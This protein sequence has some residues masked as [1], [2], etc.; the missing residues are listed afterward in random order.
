MLDIRPGSNTSVTLMPPSSTANVS[1]PSETTVARPLTAPP[2]TQETLLIETANSH[3]SGTSLTHPFVEGPLPTPVELVF[4]NTEE[5]APATV[6]PEQSDIEAPL[7]TL[8]NLDKPL[9]PPPS[10][11]GPSLGEVRSKPGAVIKPGE[12]SP[13][14]PKLHAMLGKLGYKVQHE[15]NCLD[16][17]LLRA[18]TVFQADAGIAKR[19]SDYSGI[20]GP[21]TLKCLDN[22]VKWG[23]LKDKE[24]ANSLV[25]AGKGVYTGKSKCLEGVWRT[26]QAVFN[27]TSAITAEK[28]F[29]AADEL[30]RDK[31][32]KE[33]KVTPEMYQA[34]MKGDKD[35]QDL[36]HGV[37]VIYNRSSGFSPTSGHAEIW[38]MKNKKTL[39]G[40]G[41]ASMNRSGHMI[42]NARFF[43]PALSK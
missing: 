19:G 13:D 24:T 4:P 32:F 29:E 28:A 9:P 3:H 35:M 25:S 38:D 34:A 37:Q 2:V 30:A 22:A 11:V 16:G 31:R 14:L 6:T 23:V 17:E 26:Q 15:G 36:L 18:L 40:L 41:E 10:P 27:N 20:V 7:P 33:I 8:I 39:Y 43:V 5:V 1:A 12:S 21:Q 42:Q